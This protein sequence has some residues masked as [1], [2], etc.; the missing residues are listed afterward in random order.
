MGT[1]CAAG[2]R[3]GV[4]EALEDHGWGRGSG[5]N[6][7]LGAL[8]KRI[9]GSRGAVL[10][11]TDAR[12]RGSFT[13]ANTIARPSLLEL[14]AR[15]AS[16]P[17]LVSALAAVL[18]A[19]PA[20][21]QAVRTFVS[22]QGLDTNA[23][24]VTAPCRTFQ[25]ALAV[26]A[27]GGE[28][29]V[30]NTAGYGSL[31]ITKAVSIVADGVTAGVL[32]PS[33][34]T[35]VTVNAGPNDV[36]NL[37]GLDVEGQGSAAQG[38]VFNTGQALNIQKTTVRGFA[39]A[40]INFVPNASAS[41]FVSDSLVANNG[42]YGILIDPTGS[43][44]VN[45]VMTRVLVNQNGMASNGIGIFVYGALGTGTLNIT[46]ADS[47]TASN[48]YGI[49]ASSSTVMVRNSTISN[50]VVGIRADH[51][52]NVL[53]GQSTLTGN[54]TGWQATNGGVL[55]SYTNNNVNGNT[56]N[57]SASGSVGLQ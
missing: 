8:C 22:A 52:A 25:A 18:Q 51:A 21:A 38:I 20:Q 11:F 36:I 41:I 31:T 19:V 12:R 42:S 34:G 37:R 7:G 54:G 1:R 3:G 35:G 28:I 14:F 4:G 10:P 27:P 24:S 16:L 13:R 9:P 44:A 53:V 46:V 26:T 30:L 17:L 47:V 15:R 2:W 32:G 48:Y 50:N 39:Y 57:G 45:G 23:C 33:G 56:A 43:G 6:C 5:T 40:G 29:N 55:S 49:A